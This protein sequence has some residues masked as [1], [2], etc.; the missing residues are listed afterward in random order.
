MIVGVGADVEHFRIVL[1]H[2]SARQARHAQKTDRRR[3]E[4]VAPRRSGVYR[5]L[6][7]HVIGNR[8]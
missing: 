1:R 4:E 3:G 6:Q 2:R 7:V 8:G 5:W